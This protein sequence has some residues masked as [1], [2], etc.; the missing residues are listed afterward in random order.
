M[1]SL[2][3]GLGAL[4]LLI[5]MQFAS[6]NTLLVIA[7]H[8]RDLDYFKD[9]TQYPFL[10][11]MDE[12]KEQFTKHSEKRLVYIRIYKEK[13]EK[14][15][16]EFVVTGLGK[17]RV[18]KFRNYGQLADLYQDFLEGPTDLILFGHTLN[19]KKLKK[20]LPTG[21]VKFE[22]IMS[23]ACKMA[24][25][26]NLNLFGRYT[27]IVLASPENVHLSH[28]EHLNIIETMSGNALEKAYQMSAISF[29]RILGFTK[30]N[31]VLNIYDTSKTI[32]ADICESQNDL[33]SILIDQKIQTSMFQRRKPTN[34]QFI[35]KDCQRSLK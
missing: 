32:P 5:S 10:M 28:F 4:I 33:S 21:P 12:L 34:S 18:R 15:T 25:V 11:D 8:T 19:I 23:S 1:T 20:F 30:S 16:G 27:D 6:A 22:T 35:L 29:D 7:D 9:L 31:L 17:K 3:K 14:M 24:T 13:N 2:F 26:S